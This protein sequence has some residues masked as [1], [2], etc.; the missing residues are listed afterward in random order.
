MGLT[1]IIP[2]LKPRR[3]D[4]K[5]PV[6]LIL[7]YIPLRPAWAELR[8]SSSRLRSRSPFEVELLPA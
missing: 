7:R 6:L 1:V 5:S 8:L 3:I 2:E 4:R